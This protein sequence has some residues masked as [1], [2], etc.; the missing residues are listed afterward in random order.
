MTAKRSSLHIADVELSVTR[1][2][3]LLRPLRNKC[4][5]LAST[6]SR[7]SGSAAPITYAS[8]SLSLL[9]A[10]AP[11]PLDVLHDPKHII[12]R[13]HQESRSLDAQARQIYAVTNAYRNVVQAA[14][15]EAHDGSR[16]A[17]LPLTDVCAASVGRSIRGEVARCLAAIEGGPDETQETALI[18]ELY[19]S[20]P[21]RFRR[22]VSCPSVTRCTGS[23]L[24]PTAGLSLRMRHAKSSTPAPITRCSCS[25][26]SEWP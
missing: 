24:K 3:R 26:F 11:T 25:V 4:A 22:C 14:L 7:P 5:V 16:R 8:S 10:R 13:T 19:E 20:V 23:H 1:I 9:E 12:S 21:V 17:L 15:P 6:T 2:N 18:D